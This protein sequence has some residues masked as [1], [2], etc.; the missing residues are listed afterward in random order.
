MKKLQVTPYLINIINIHTSP[1]MIRK[2]DDT[3]ISSLKYFEVE[4]PKFGRF[5]LLPKAH[6]I[7]F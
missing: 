3:D 6:Y 7:V 5:Y 1:E 2:R 4:E